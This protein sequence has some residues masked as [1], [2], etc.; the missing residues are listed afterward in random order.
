MGFASISGWTFEKTVPIALCDNA[1]RRDPSMPGTFWV[2]AAFAPSGATR[3]ERPPTYRSYL[4]AGGRRESGAT[5]GVLPDGTDDG[6]ASAGNRMASLAGS[7]DCVV[8][9]VVPA[10]DAEATSEDD[11]EP[12]WQDAEW[13]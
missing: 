1:V 4:A 2:T 12:T 5:A 7:A 10:G 11:E 8:I 9:L 13:Q 6:R 3:S